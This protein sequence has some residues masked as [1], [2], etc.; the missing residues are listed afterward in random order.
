MRATIILLY[1][2]A[3]CAE[4]DR[5]TFWMSRRMKLVELF[6]NDWMKPFPKEGRR[7]R[8]GNVNFT[9]AHNHMHYAYVYARV[10]VPRTFYQ[11]FRICRA[12]RFSTRAMRVRWPN[13][14]GSPTKLYWPYHTLR[15]CIRPRLISI[16]LYIHF[17]TIKDSLLKY[18]KSFA[19][20]SEEIK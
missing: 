5:A 18:W 4:A 12:G 14:K 8:T 20:Q 7:A 6:M 1:S 3:S 13:V 11:L 17:K 9:V 19:K 2:R 15:R 16:A 10:H